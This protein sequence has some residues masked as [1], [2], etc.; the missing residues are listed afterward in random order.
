MGPITR[1]LTAALDD[2]RRYRRTLTIERLS[3]DRDAQHAVSHA[4]WLAAEAAVSLVIGVRPGSQPARNITYHKLFDAA[5]DAGRLPPELAMRLRRWVSTARGDYGSAF[6]Y[7]EIDWRAMHANLSGIGD[8]EQ[9]AALVQESPE[10]FPDPELS[11]LATAAP[12]RRT[13][14]DIASETRPPRVSVAMLQS[15]GNTV[16][17]LKRYRESATLETLRTDRQSL[18]KVLHALQDARDLALS[19]AAGYDETVGDVGARFPFLEERLRAGVDAGWLPADVADRLVHWG[20]F[21][22]FLALEDLTDGA[23]GSTDGIAVARAWLDR[24]YELED[25]LAVVQ[26][27]ARWA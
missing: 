14:R 2:L 22:S 8:L 27:W 25:A 15:L 20:S 3:T 16:E 6:G 26:R 13:A 12:A 21:L 4:F 9:L 23:P 24:V 19:I 1:T 7:I 10:K 5:V 18:R 11:E 17:D